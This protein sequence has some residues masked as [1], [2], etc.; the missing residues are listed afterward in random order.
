M[1]TISYKIYTDVFRT[2]TSSWLSLIKIYFSCQVSIRSILFIHLWEFRQTELINFEVN[3]QGQDETRYGQKSLVQK[4]TFLAKAYQLMVDHGRPF[5]SSYYLLTCLTHL[6]HITGYM[7]LVYWAMMN[8]YCYFGKLSR[9]L[10]IYSFAVPNALSCV[11]LQGMVYQSPYCSIVSH[12]MHKRLTWILFW[13]LLILWHFIYSRKS[14]HLIVFI[15][16]P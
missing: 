1:N 14:C 13:L 3:G 15:M 8:V 5:R 10:S 12:C 2:S 4:Y 16:V 9:G 6:C 11:V 7:K